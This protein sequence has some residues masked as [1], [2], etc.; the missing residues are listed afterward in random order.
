MIKLTKYSFY[1]TKNVIL[2]NLVPINVSLDFN[3]Y[4]IYQRS[5]RMKD[6]ITT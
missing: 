5:M 6:V 2:Q 1:K 3:I 4:F